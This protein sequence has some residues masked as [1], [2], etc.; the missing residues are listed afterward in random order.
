M[1]KYCSFIVLVLLLSVSTACGNKAVDDVNIVT[2]LEAT[3]FVTTTETT[4]VT[5]TETPK[6]L[7]EDCDTLLCTG[8]DGADYYELVANQIDGYPDSTFEFGVLKNNEWLVQMNSDC[9]FI[10]ENGWWKGATYDNVAGEFEYVD[11]GCFYYRRA[12]ES[13]KGG[14]IYKPETGVHFEVVW[15]GS[16]SPY[17]DSKEEIY[18]KLIN[19]SG[20]YLGLLNDF[21]FSCMNLNTGETRAIPLEL[22]GIGNNQ[23]IGLLSD[24]LFYAHASSNFTGTDYKGFYDLHGNQII[25]LTEYHCTDYGDYMFHNGEYTITC[26]NNSGVEFDITFDTSGKIIRQEKSA[27]Q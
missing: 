5:T 17:S 23:E 25:D 7:S 8:Y 3:D 27:V 19:K 20:E 15:F 22:E 2:T 16:F 21:T 24:G 9:P 26:K 4:Y 6:K 14:I 12:D 11:A 18:S 1:K 13:S 10:D